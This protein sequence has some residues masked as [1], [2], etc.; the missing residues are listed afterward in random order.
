M[1]RVGW[2]NDICV[3]VVEGGVRGRMKDVQGVCIV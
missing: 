2:T 3:C 1:G